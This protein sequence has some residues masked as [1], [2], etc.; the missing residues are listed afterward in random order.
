M[1]SM[2]PVDRMAMPLMLFYPLK[3]SNILIKY[4]LRWEFIWIGNALRV[5]PM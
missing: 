2:M 1:A 4:V 5:L 3:S